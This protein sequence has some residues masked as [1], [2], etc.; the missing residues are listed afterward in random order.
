MGALKVSCGLIF[1]A[2]YFDP[3]AENCKA[4][5][6]ENGLVTG[7]E[8]VYVEKPAAKYRLVQVLLIDEAHAGGRHTA[9]VN[10]Q[11]AS[12]AMAGDVPFLAWP[13]PTPHSALPPGN[14]NNEHMIYSTYSPPAIGPLGIYVGKGTTPDVDSDI[15]YG[16][17]LPF[18]RHISY[19]LSFVE[20]A[21]V[22]PEPPDPPTPAG[23]ALE[24][25]AD[26][27]ERLTVHL[28]A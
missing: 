16:L 7:V 28:G 17:G 18:N 6:E 27:V 10:V 9:K 8:L 26:A 3:R 23:D 24:R 1:A 5:R 11:L 12:G 14:P 4:Y 2:A 15:V 19:S 13:F 21:G 22:D 25:I 20:R